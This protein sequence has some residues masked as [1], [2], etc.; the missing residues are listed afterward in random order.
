MA[1]R[2]SC[3]GNTPSLDKIN[4]NKI[5]KNSAAH[6]MKQTSIVNFIDN[7]KDKSAIVTLQHD[8]E[9]Q[10]PL[11]TEFTPRSLIKD[12]SKFANCNNWLLSVPPTEVSGD[13]I[14]DFTVGDSGFISQPIS[15]NFFNNLDT[16]H[17]SL[18][19][20]KNAR[21]TKRGYDSRFGSLTP[22]KVPNRLINKGA[23]VDTVGADERSVSMNFK[24]SNTGG[25]TPQFKSHTPF[26]Q[27]DEDRDIYKVPKTFFR[28]E[29]GLT[30][31]RTKPFFRS[32]RVGSAGGQ[33]LKA[34][35][36]FKNSSFKTDTKSF[37]KDDLSCST[38][39]SFEEAVRWSMG[40]KR[41]IHGCD[42]IK[43]FSICTFI[44]F[45]FATNLSCI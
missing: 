19:C 44:L 6:N 9:K 40:M 22:A 16:N 15:N 29:K 43:A 18:K 20:H 45:T 35:L 7:K 42:S 34:N 11:L 21:F 27:E 8:A 14:N 2:Y 37:Y 3:H 36:A 30:I 38:S 1:Q 41:A 33:H 24:D 10:P 32:S 12:C 26:L 13:F 4:R 17:I 25:H 39:H 28:D 5:T 23:G 31:Y